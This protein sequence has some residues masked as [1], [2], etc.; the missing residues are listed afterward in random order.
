MEDALK[1]EFYIEMC[2]LE[3]WSSR[4]LQE[5][6]KS[7]LYERTAISK[8]P[9]ETIQQELAL[10]KSEQQLSTDLVFHDPY[11]RRRLHLEHSVS[12]CSIKF[13]DSVYSIFNFSA[14]SGFRLVPDK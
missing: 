7:M 6:I 5:R 12:L 10:L 14:L 9:D 2:K 4:Q 11:F 1:R 8:K 3:K 13:V